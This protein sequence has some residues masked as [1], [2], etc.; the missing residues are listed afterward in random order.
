MTGRELERVLVEHANSHKNITLFEDNI[1][2]DLITCSTRMKRG[3]VTTTHEDYC[4]G[5]YV[6][7]RLTNRV[8]T[9][10]SK[11]TLLATGGAGKVYLYTSNPDVATGD[12]IAM[13]YR[14]GATLANLEFV[15]FH[16][17]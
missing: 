4:C 13:S 10:S 12:G 14:A 16:P 17:T 15:Q 11:I 7:D 6:L 5:A 8:K 9:F 2:I 3:L 1:A